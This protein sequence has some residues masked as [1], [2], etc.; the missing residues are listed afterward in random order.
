MKLPATTIRAMTGDHRY[1]LLLLGLFLNEAN[2]LRKLLVKAALGIADEP[3]GQ[4]NFALT[5]LLATTLAGKIHE[6]WNVITD[7]KLCKILDQIGLPAE[8]SELRQKITDR[9][10]T[11]L[12]LR[13]RNNIAF[14]YPKRKL[15]FANLASHLD[16]SDTVIY[17][18][19]EGYGGDVLWQISTIAGIEP[20]LALHPAA[21]YRVSIKAVWDEVTE[22]TGLYC[23]FVTDAVVTIIL[24]SI[25]DLSV[26]DL[27]IPDAPEADADPFRFF[28]HPPTDLEEMRAAVEKSD[29]C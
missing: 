17:I 18:A 19:P 14:H 11:D 3:E 28:V 23:V 22:V 6:G 16:D 13:I 2:W 21:D 25:P 20:L 7:G 10:S 15:D 29:D 8:A 5:A 1:A 27:I 24:R 9:L 26:E 4:A 12:F